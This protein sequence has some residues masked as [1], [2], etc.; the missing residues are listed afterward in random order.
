MQINIKHQSQIS[1]DISSKDSFL[2]AGQQQEILDD[3]SEKSLPELQ[4][5]SQQVRN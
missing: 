5:P 1:F 4:P 2:I 3:K